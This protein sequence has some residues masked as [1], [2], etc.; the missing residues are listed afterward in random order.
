M[1]NSYR[2][3]C[4]LNDIEKE[5]YC[6]DYLNSIKKIHKLKIDIKKKE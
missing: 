5:N 4:D 2:G 3:C 1:N 6:I